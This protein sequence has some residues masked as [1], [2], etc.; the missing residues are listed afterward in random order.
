[1]SYNGLEDTKKIDISKPRE[2]LKPMYIAMD[3]E[4]KQEQELIKLLQEFHD[5]FVWSFRDLKGVDQA[6]C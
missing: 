1:M 4:P 5:I 2:D 3:L 6:M